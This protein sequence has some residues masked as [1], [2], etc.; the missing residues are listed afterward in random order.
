MITRRDIGDLHSMV[1]Q[2][3][4]HAENDPLFVQVQPGFVQVSKQAGQDRDVLFL[5]FLGA[6]TGLEAQGVALLP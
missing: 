4:R 6:E 2:W 1:L 5:F 3:F